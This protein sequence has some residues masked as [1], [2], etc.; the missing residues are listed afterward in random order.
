MAAGLVY[1]VWVQR[2]DLSFPFSILFA[3]SF[4]KVRQELPERVSTPERCHQEMR[5]TRIDGSWWA[6]ILL[7]IVSWLRAWAQ[8]IFIAYYSYHFINSGYDVGISAPIL[9]VFLLA[10]T[11]GTLAGGLFADWLGRRTVITGSLVLGL[12]A[13]WL[14]LTP[15]G[16]L[17][18]GIALL[19]QHHAMV[20]V[21]ALLSPKNRYPIALVWLPTDGLLTSR[22]TM[23]SH[24]RLYRRYLV[25]NGSSVPVRTG[26]SIALLLYS[27]AN[28]AE[29]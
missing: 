12:V 8:Y 13:L 16:P 4:L 24:H 5:D 11:V 10:G 18:W 22:R 9:S 3:V 20:P 26:I 15:P 7:V 23:Y 2:I 25:F 6:V 27:T 1:T 19:E 14:S 21:R 17:A 28:R 29:R